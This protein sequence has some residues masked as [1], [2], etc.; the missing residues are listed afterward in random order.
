MNDQ[1]Q[2]LILFGDKSS[3]K[4]YFGL[5]LAKELN[6]PLVEIDQLIQ[7]QH[8]NEFHKESSCREIFT[9]KGEQYFRLLEE[10]VIHELEVKVKCIIAVGGGALLNEKNQLQLQT[11]GKLVYLEADKE[12]IKNRIFNS[13]IPPYLDSSDPE[14][15]FEKVYEKRRLR[16]QKISPYKIQLLNKTDA[17][18]V[19]ELIKYY[20]TI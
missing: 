12:T 4:S 6:I 5:L 14:N 10:R 9:Q 20:L 7:K 19:Q 13:G 17:Q 16:Y 2:N 3:G 1:L 18:I 15:S 8:K 11:L